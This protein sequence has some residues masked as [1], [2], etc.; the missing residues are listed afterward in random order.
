[1]GVTAARGVMVMAMVMM[2]V[3]MLMG[4]SAG[5][6]WTQWPWVQKKMTTWKRRRL[7]VPW[8]A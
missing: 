7:L 2:M 3:M 8:Q 5:T 1:M 6:G 4:V